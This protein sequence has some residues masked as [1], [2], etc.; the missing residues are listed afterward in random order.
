M[1]AQASLLTIIYLDRDTSH[2]EAFVQLA[3]HH[4]NQQISH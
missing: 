4:L 1:H 3:P 2:G